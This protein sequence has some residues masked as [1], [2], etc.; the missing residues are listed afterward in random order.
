MYLCNPAN[1]SV[2]AV[3]VSFI[4]QWYFVASIEINTLPVVISVAAVVAQWS[5]IMLSD[6]QQPFV[7]HALQKHNVSVNSLAAQYY[8]MIY[9]L[10]TIHPFPPQ[11]KNRDNIWGQCLCIGQKQV[12]STGYTRQLTSRGTIVRKCL[13]PFRVERPTRMTGGQRLGHST[14][15]GHPLRQRIELHPRVARFRRAAWQTIQSI[16]PSITALFHAT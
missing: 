2:K 16:H 10:L 3:K 1:L 14:F 9:G 4:G 7:T 5:H 11:K 6:Q 12:M 8:L 15:F 13:K